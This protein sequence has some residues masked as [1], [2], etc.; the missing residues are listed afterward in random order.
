MK[1]LL[2]KQA[3]LDIMVIPEHDAWL[4]LVSYYHD[5][6]KHCDVFKIDNGSGDH[7]YALFSAQGA[8]LKGFDHESSLSPHQNENN[9]FSS[10]IYG[11]VP[12]HL[13]QLL[14]ESMEKDDVT[15]YLWQE[16]D[17]TQWHRSPDA[18]TLQQESSSDDGG[19]SFLLGYIFPSAEEWYRWAVIY[20]ELQE[21]AW[22]AV[23][24]LYETGEITRSMVEDLNPERDY[25][26][27]L[28]EC[29]VS[30]LLEK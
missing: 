20:Y 30:G 14:D 29:I 9:L 19:Q 27:I 23:A 24:Q 18:N 25:D 4:R 11:N 7:L 3:I 21:E 1:E 15:F 16:A 10:E 5:Q 2:K 28:D 8:L 22:D 26:T 13:L 6:D 17:E 12:P